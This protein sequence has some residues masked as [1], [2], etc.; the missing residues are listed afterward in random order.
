MTARLNRTKNDSVYNAGNINRHHVN[1]YHF[2]E[3]ED[4]LSDTSLVG[5]IYSTKHEE[6]AIKVHDMVERQV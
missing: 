5:H 6:V 2:Q 1:Y 3:E 4:P